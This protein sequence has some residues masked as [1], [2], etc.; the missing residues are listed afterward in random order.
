MELTALVARR[1]MVRAFTDE[2]IARSTIEDIIG[3]ALRAPSAGFSQGVSFVLVTEVEQRRRIADIAGEAWYLSVGHPPFLSSAPAQLIV[4]TSERVYRDRYLEQDKRQGG[5]GR[6]DWPVPYWYTDAGCALMLLLLA[7]EDAGLAAAFVGTR[8]PRLLNAELNI[9]TDVVPIGILA[10]GHRGVDKRTRSAQ[11]RR[12]TV[13]EALHV[14][15][16]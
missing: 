12:R 13:D 3:V 10:V 16:W 5:K 2:P 8:D 4:C 1:R 9:P 14:G 7:I 11:R 15:H 6:A